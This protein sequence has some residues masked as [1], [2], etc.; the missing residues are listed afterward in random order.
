MTPETIQLESDCLR[1]LVAPEV[2]GRIVSIFWKPGGHELLWRNSALP[3]RRERP[4]SGYDP[5]FFGGIDE[6]LPSDVPERVGGLEYPDH[7]EVWTLPLEARFVGRELVLGGTLPICGL[8]L[9]RRIS[10]EERAPRVDLRY[11]IS[12]L[13]AAPRHFLWRIH[14]ALAVD[15]GDVIS[16]PARIARVADPAWSRFRSQEPF[17]WPI[18]EGKDASVLPAPDGTTDSFFLEDLEAGLLG[19]ERRRLGLTCSFEFDPAVLPCA[20]IFLSHGGLLG[21]HVAVLEPATARGLSVTEALATGD[22]RPLGP[23]S[24]IETLV[25]IRVEPAGPGVSG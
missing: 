10:L 23:G 5:S 18:I 21:H 20:C 11:R 3:L 25:S 15:A 13:S 12:N 24:S 9:E 6:L 16:C 4:G 19:L 2:G 7:G 22:C 14:A 8:R 17:R 1:A